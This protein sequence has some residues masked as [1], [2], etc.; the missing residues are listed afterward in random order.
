MLGNVRRSS[1][2][3]C[4][5]GVPDLRPKDKLRTAKAFLWGILIVHRNLNKLD[6]RSVHRKYLEM[7]AA[8]KTWERAL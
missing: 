5:S 4:L 1:P 2:L 6:V 3:F 8:G 7:R